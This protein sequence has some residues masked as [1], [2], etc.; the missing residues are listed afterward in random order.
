MKSIKYIALSAFLTVSAL[1]AVLYNSCTKDKCKGVTCQN[2]GTC[3]GGNCVCPSGS[4]GT[5]CETIY[6][7]SFVNTY[8][9]TGTDD[10]TP[11]NTYTDFRFIFSIPSSSTDLVTMNI[12][13]Q[14]NTGAAAGI[15]VLTVTLA[16]F[17]ASGATFTVNSTTSGGLT[18]TGS[19]T[20]SG[21]TASIILKETP[22][23]GSAL[24][25]TFAALAKV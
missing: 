15:P 14:D 16:N 22:T 2:G 24:T 21:T 10:G 6:E 17:S 3:S 5:S 13:I 7:E 20:I 25:Y 12:T 9:G 23:T 4:T 11:V 19:G 1:S 18:Y 8:K